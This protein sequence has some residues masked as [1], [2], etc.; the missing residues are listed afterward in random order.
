MI[1]KNYQQLNYWNNKNYPC[2][3]GSIKIAITCSQTIINIFVMSERVW[4]MENVECVVVEKLEQQFSFL[5]FAALARLPLGEMKWRHC[6]QVRE[7]GKFMFCWFSTGINFHSRVIFRLLTY[8][9]HM[10][11]RKCMGNEIMLLFGLMSINLTE[12]WFIKK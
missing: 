8:S 9:L 12:V 6:M 4:I 1:T 10:T 5:L 2:C 11:W 3:C 7:N